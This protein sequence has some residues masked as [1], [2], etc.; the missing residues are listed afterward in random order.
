MFKIPF[1]HLPIRGYGLMLMIGFLGGTW[2]AA[3]RASRVKC[4]P[5]MVVNLGFFALLSS[6]I[7]ARI[8]HVVHY[9]DSHFAG[10]GLAAVIDLTSGGLE[11]YGGFIAAFI[12]VVIF[13]SA[14]KVSVRLYLDIIAPSLMFG[15]GMARIGCFLNGCCWGGPC[16]AE[17]PWAVQFPYAS[18]ATYRQWED[19]LITLP[20]ELILIDQHGNPAHPYLMPRDW[21]NMSTEE[22]YGPKLAVRKAR[23]ELNQAKLNNQDRET[24]A[25]LQKI[26]NKKIKAQ[27]KN[28][29]VTN[30]LDMQ[31]KHFDLTPSQ[32]E[33]L[34]NA[35]SVKTLHVHPV[36]LYASLNGL[37]LA[38]LLNVIFYRRKRHGTVAGLIFLLYPIMRILEEIIRID[39]PHDTAG[40]T[41]SQFLS[42]LIFMGGLIYMYIIYRLPLRSP[43]AIPYVPPPLNESK[44]KKKKK[45]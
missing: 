3:R 40:L 43:R 18:P 35:P 19:R 8:F 32:L 24:I 14:Q 38:M 31:E 30:T 6:V 10:R 42:V 44:P 20:A 5:D 13:M 4:D 23:E 29:G 16:T 7:G 36:Q 28:A 34:A 9:W 21:I 25:K 45:K 12:T 15:M 37:L 2:W 17:L 33:Q 41:V 39:N 27:Q 22:R 1:F 11:F 26:L